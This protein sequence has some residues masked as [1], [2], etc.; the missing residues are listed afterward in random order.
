MFLLKL[1]SELRNLIKNSN[2]FYIY[3]QNVGCISTKRNAQPPTPTPTFP[4]SPKKLRL[5]L[6]LWS[7]INQ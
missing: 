2:P 4:L 5:N 7:E 3:K 1:A 6:L